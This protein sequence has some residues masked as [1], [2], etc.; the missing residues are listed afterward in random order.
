MVSPGHILVLGANVLY[1]TVPTV[2]TVLNAALLG[3]V[4]WV[5]H[6]TSHEM[7]PRGGE[8]QL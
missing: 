8:V 5:R 1:C 7:Q 3:G 6:W 2:S 4:S